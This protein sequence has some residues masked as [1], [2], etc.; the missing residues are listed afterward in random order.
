MGGKH[1]KTGRNDPCPCGS[2]LKFKKCCGKQSQQSSEPIVI[3][4]APAGPGV[5]RHHGKGRRDYVFSAFPDELQDPMP[6]C[7]AWVD[8]ELC[9]RGMACEITLMD[10][11]TGQLQPM[12]SCPIFEVT[13]HGMGE[14]IKEWGTM[15]FFEGLRKSFE[16]AV[17][18]ALEKMGLP[19][20]YDNSW[21]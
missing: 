15:E 21:V 11:K 14:E 19:R 10:T 16:K 20:S 4:M 6:I 9:S 12:F 1:S 17:N 7:S 5:Y 3:R 13:K 8:A 2:K 18:D